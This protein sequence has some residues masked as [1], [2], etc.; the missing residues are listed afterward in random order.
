MNTKE[1]LNKEIERVKLTSDEMKNIESLAKKINDSIKKRL[2]KKKIN[3]QVF[4]GGSLAKKTIIKKPSYDIDIFL[5]FDKGYS[6][7]QIKKFM[8]KIFFL[9]SVKGYRTSVKKIHGSRDY[10]SIVLKKYHNLKFEIVPILKINSPE[11]ARNITDLSFF[12]VNYIKKQFEK[13]K[14]IISQILLAKSFCYAQK[15]YGAESYVNGLSGYALELLLSY[16]KDF[17]RFTKEIAEAKEKII[18]DP[19]KHYKN[20]EEILAMEKM[21]MKQEVA[22]IKNLRLHQNFGRMRDVL[23]VS[24]GGLHPGILDQIFDMYGTTDIGIQVG[25]GV[26]GHPD[27]IEAGAKAVCQAVD[28]YKQNIS[29]KEYSKTHKELA[30]ALEKWG[31]MRPV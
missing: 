18:I 12:H 15:C 17:F 13:D 7:E 8:R 1:I 5:R 3:A 24:S 23:P 16:Y 10:Y 27:G 25:G 19:A 4:I 14:N 28:A 11:E 20:K 22:E 21:L 26:Q 6:E 30:R 29:L 9:F 31:S 2:D